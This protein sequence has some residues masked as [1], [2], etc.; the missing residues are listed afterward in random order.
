MA[1]KTAK[2]KSVA[3]AKTEVVTR[4]DINRLT[5]ILERIEARLGEC[6]CQRRNRTILKSGAV[7]LL[8]A[9]PGPGDADWEDI[10]E[11]L[12]E[13]FREDGCQRTVLRGSLITS[14]G[15]DGLGYMEARFAAGMEPRINAE[16]NPTPVAFRT[17]MGAMDD[18]MVR[19]L[20]DEIIDLGG[21]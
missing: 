4:E 2:N 21:K 8:A 11:R 13:C 16:F 1:S 18:K 15:E 7:A 20:V 12:K 5:M 14:S 17:P 3:I 6:C 19:W 10:Y 9:A